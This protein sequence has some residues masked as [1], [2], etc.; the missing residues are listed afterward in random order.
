MVY[1][2]EE[3]GVLTTISRGWRGDTALPPFVM[4]GQERGM[5][6]K[7]I[8]KEWWQADLQSCLY[9]LLWILRSNPY[10]DS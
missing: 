1:D 8:E 6:E 5:R 7:G 9:L 4:R 2:A 3:A 10:P